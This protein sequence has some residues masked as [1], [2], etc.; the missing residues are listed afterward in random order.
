M[1]SYPSLPTAHPRRRDLLLGAGALAGAAAARGFGR[2]ATAQAP[3]DITFAF[4]P[5]RSGS[6]QALVDAFNRAQDGRVRVR[7]L[8]MPVDTDDYRR[9]LESEFEVG[10]SEIDVIAADVIWTAEF[11]DRR[12]AQDLTARFSR[13]YRPEAFLKASIDSAAFQNRIWAVPWFADVG[14]L[15]YRRDLLEGSGFAEPPRTWGELERMALEVKEKAG[16]PHGFLFQGAAYE[17]GVAN[18]CE[19]IW[20]AGGRVMTTGLAVSGALGPPGVGPDASLIDSV[21]AARGLEIARGL[22][23]RGVAPPEVADFNEQDALQVFAAGEA[24]FMRGWPFVY[25]ILRAGDGPVSADQVGIA[26]I[27]TATPDLPS[28]GCLGGWNLMISSLSQHA[29][30][31]WDFIRFAVSPEQQRRHAQGGGFLPTLRALYDEPAIGQELPVTREGLPAIR[32]ARTRPASPFYP[33]V[34]TRIALAFNRV[35]RGELDGLTAVRR[36]DGEFRTILRRGR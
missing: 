15:Y 27:P 9:L 7:W 23:A 25:G 30:P 14:M 20:S 16:V 21:D 19:Y 18:A 22:I 31:A 6:T 2:P 36:L 1:P 5:D 3:E 29:A 28:F 34:S 8:E 13:S 10:A 11:A 17:G 35:L 24:V 32:T 26:P 4:A 12:W 33:Q